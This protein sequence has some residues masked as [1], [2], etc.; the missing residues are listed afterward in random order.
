MLIK[1]EMEDMKEQMRLVQNENLRDKDELQQLRAL[2][3]VISMVWL[4]DAHSVKSNI[5]L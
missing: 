5:F 4:I 2:Y 1:A 3:K